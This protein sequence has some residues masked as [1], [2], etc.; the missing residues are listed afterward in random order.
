MSIDY[1]GRKP[2]S[3]DRKLFE[4]ESLEQFQDR[5][6]K[7]AFGQEDERG[8]AT[9]ELYSDLAKTYLKGRVL[10]DAL[11]KMDP[12]QFIPIEEFADSTRAAAIRI[13]REISKDG[14]IITYSMYQKAVD[15]ILERKWEIRATVL[16]LQI[17]ASSAQNAEETKALISNTKNSS[18]LLKEFISENGIVTTIIGMLTIS[19]FQTIIFQAL[20]V[21]EGAKGIQLS[22]IPAGIAL[23][24]EIG[25][26]PERIKSIL[27]DSK[28]S[29]PLV[30]EQID[31]LAN[32]D[33]ARSNA[34][35]GIGIDYD[36]FKKSQEFTDCEDIVNYVSQYYGRYG[37]L[38]RPNGHLSIDHWV[39][40]LR[41]AQNQQTLRGALNT[42]HKF[43]QK[44]QNI[45]DVN[46]IGVQDNQDPNIFNSDSK[47]TSKIFTQLASAV[48]VLKETSN[49]I[50][51]DIA[52][53]FTY[54]LT[55]RDLCC[56]VQIFGEIANP[57]LMQT[58]AS[59]LRILSVDI[60]GSIVNIQS[61]LARLLANLAQDALF[62]LM[63]NVNEFYYK[64]AHK[65]TKAFTV[66]IQG[67]EACSAML[68]LGWSLL[69]AVNTIFEQA[70]KLLK[71]ISSII[72]DVGNNQSGE[73]EAAA[74]RRHLLGIA[75]L[76]E[77]L[78]FRLDLANTCDT[79]RSGTTSSI[80]QIN[81]PK[82]YMNEAIFDI[83]GS[84]PPVIA[85]SEE[86]RGRYFPEVKKTT[87]KR[88]KFSYGIESE[89]NTEDSPK[90]CIESDQKARL[91]ALIDNIKKAVTEN[92]NG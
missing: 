58:I 92:F 71:E 35:S 6:E 22:Q 73:W 9:D 7:N 30:E 17:P 41:V 27:K 89:Q 3:R 42:S 75:R 52:N 57:K 65:I 76:L 5:I 74:D 16:D 64:I 51:D 4:T 21:E 49:T 56:L 10:R 31:V 55:D 18:P 24:L 39:A 84:A 19:P 69:N 48:V 29:T 80:D 83:L 67:F 8:K 2:F 26:K 85:F 86:D 61:M 66:D 53:S 45:K 25:I 72:G 12:A 78:A 14:D 70:N 47:K 13:A 20:G 88:L 44:F 34:M 32:S 46:S 36:E 63:A 15:T 62:E 77:V 38:D 28:I 23:F 33:V 87:S 11:S 50:Y 79:S 37:G 40:Y 91:S 43:S 81:D 90:D 54:Y 1:N 82:A 68:P 59:L 60:G